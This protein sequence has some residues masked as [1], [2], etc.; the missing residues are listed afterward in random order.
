MNNIIKGWGKSLGLFEVTEEEKKMS[1]ERLSKCAKCKYSKETRIL[2]I[3]QRKAVDMPG[4]Y[5]RK[6]FCPV[7]E[8]SLVKEEKCRM[9]L[10]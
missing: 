9:G 1:L 10:W 5:C 4:Y 6:C 8:K 7:N 3:V 2:K